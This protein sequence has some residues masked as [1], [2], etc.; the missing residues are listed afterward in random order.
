MSRMRNENFRQ[1]VKTI[2][3]CLAAFLLAVLFKTQAFSQNANPLSGRVTDST[4]QPIPGVSIRIKGA[5]TGTATDT[6]GRF[7]INAASA[8]KIVVSAVGYGEQE[9]S[10]NGKLSSIVLKQ[11]AGQLDDVVVVGYGTQ[12]KTTLSGAV[13]QVKGD[14]V[15][16]GRATTSAAAALQGQ[17]PGLTITRTSSRPGNEGIGVQ[18]RGGISVNSVEPLLMID[19]VASYMW[20]LSQINPTDIENISVLKDAAAAIY[21]TRAAG[22]VILVT[23]KRGRPGGVKVAYSGSGHQ[24]FEGRRFPVASGVEWAQM[25]IEANKND[26][27]ASGTENNWWL[28]TGEEYQR[29]ANGEAFWRSDNKLRLD[30]H[31]NQ[32]DAVYGSTWGQQH[33]VS[34]TGGSDKLRTFTSLGYADDRSL[35]DIVYDGTKKYNMR[36]N[37]DWNINKFVK[38]SVNLSYDKRNVVTPTRGVG[39]GIQD[40]YIFPLYNEKGQFYDAFGTNN[41]LAKLYEG[42]QT[43]NQETF[44]RAGGDLTI[45]MSFIRPLAGLTFNG[46]ANMRERSQNLAKRGTQVTMYDWDGETAKPNNIFYQTP[47]SDMYAENTFAKSFYTNYRF[48]ADYKRKIQQHNI[49]LMAAVTQEQEQFNNLFARRINLPSNELDAINTGDLAATTSNANSGAANAWGLVSYLGRINYDFN[50]TYILTMQYRRDGSSRLAPEN[51][52]AD[53]KGGE[54]AWRLSKYN[55]IKKVGFLNELKL[56]ASYGELGSLSGIGQ[57]D[58][59][60]N[61]S[62]GTT[63]FGTTPTSTQTAWVNGLSIRSRTWERVASTNFGLDFAVVKNRLSGSF[64]YFIRKNE[65]MLIRLGYPST[66][67]IAAPF[68]NDGNF[69][70]KG[71][72]AVLQW[73]D[74]VGKDF[75]YNIGVNLQDARTEVTKYSGIGVP[76]AGLNSV[77]QGKPINAIYVYRTNGY[78]QNEKEVTEYYASHSGQGS[79][80]PVNGTTNRLTP[81]SVN[82]IDKNGDGA[83]TTADLDYYA[84]AN[85]HYNFG[86]NLGASWKSID[87]TAFFQGI[88]QQYLVRSNQM[89]YPFASGWTSQNRTF[90]GNTW[91]EENPNAMF[92][93]LTRNG[94]RN[95]WNYGQINDINVQNVSYMRCKSMV[96]G[97]TVPK[98]VLGRVKLDRLRVWVSGDNLFEVHNVKDGF[99]PESKSATGQGNI[100]IFARTISF[101]L[102]LGF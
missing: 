21:G 10:A 45:D 98:S 85:P 72:E 100:D 35:I 58:Y 69:T 26:A 88:G 90:L 39:E 13:V 92:P 17:I 3:S 28:F 84:D 67:G 65:G 63:P 68:T 11:V 77:I 49:G 37:L 36:T 73:R 2:S 8:S 80:I 31:V 56:R 15:F 52:W 22:G 91:S 83:I 41:M 27:V 47:L 96:L 48:Q 30:P 29:L 1:G 57:Y 16:K 102:E 9:L 51:R 97:Y 75:K 4:G 70:A 82:K 23:T 101:G 12:K 66:L 20:E 38:A 62:T 18:L 6:D 24:N 55:F 79:L 87:F 50:E 32:F 43:K 74:K 71:F 33:N 59:L 46:S 53:F 64:D 93:V 40:M 7:S 95:G 44:F 86:I 99:D 5:K 94:S 42:G 14:E 54:F 89:A 76:A 34:I 78:L 60:S 25:S 61:I 81:G 19:G